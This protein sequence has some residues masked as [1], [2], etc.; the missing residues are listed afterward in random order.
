[1]IDVSR[2]VESLLLDEVGMEQL[3]REI[4]QYEKALRILQ[5][6]KASMVVDETTETKEPP[7]ANGEPV[8][9][10]RPRLQAIDRIK[11][12][13]GA[14]WLTVADIADRIGSTYGTADFV[15]KKHPETFEKR[16]K[17]GSLTRYEYRQKQA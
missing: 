13:M 7:A 6:I 5:A 9:R 16:G 3:D 15:L 1:M 8:L 10:L 2:F 17:D 14:D 4:R 12:S 11:A